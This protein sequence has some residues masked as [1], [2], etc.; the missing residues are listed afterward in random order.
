M[1]TTQEYLMIKRDGLTVWGLKLGATEVTELKMT[2]NK[3]WRDADLFY[4]N[5]WL[6]EAS[7]LQYYGYDLIDLNFEPEWC[8]RD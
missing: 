1:S 5:L 6:V 2:H 4:I 7:T 3:Y 8:I